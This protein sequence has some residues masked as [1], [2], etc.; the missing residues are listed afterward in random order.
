MSRCTCWKPI[1]LTKPGRTPRR[2]PRR[3]RARWISSRSSRTARRRRARRA[4]RIRSRGSGST[5]AT[6]KC[7]AVSTGAVDGGVRL[8][9]DDH[10][11]CSPRP[12][13]HPCARAS[14]AGPAAGAPGRS[15][16]P[17][18]AVDR[19]AAPRPSSPRRSAA[20]E[21]P[22]AGAP[23]VAA[24]FGVDLLL[25]RGRRADR[26]HLH[27]CEQVRPGRRRPCRRSCAGRRCSTWSPGAIW[28]ATPRSASTVTVTATRSSARDR[29]SRTCRRPVLRGARTSASVMN[30][31]VSIAPGGD[32]AD[33]VV[34][35]R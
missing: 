22:A 28:F 15:G 6:S 29:R 24:P 9:L 19:P 13:R 11:A 32:L 33:E 30:C 27:V 31:L 1:G 2:R 8:H 14:S 23:T 34:R 21:L 10:G 26:E 7:A 12:W 4:S 18:L 16:A 17:L 20:P 5:T 3:C 25:R 35:R